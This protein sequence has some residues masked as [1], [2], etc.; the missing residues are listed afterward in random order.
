METKTEDIKQYI[1]DNDLFT[2]PS[3]TLAKRVLT[4]NPALFGEYNDKN[5]ELSRNAVRRIRYSKGTDNAPESKLFA[6][7]FHGYL[8]P[9]INDYTPFVIPDTVT[10]MGIMNDIHIPF[11]NKENLNA[12]RNI[13]GNT[14]ETNSIGCLCDMTPKYMPLN[15]WQA[16]FAMV[17]RDNDYYKFSNFLIE[18]G[19][20]L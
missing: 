7:R 5:I 19:K 4:N 18:N 1:I 6:E 16:G 13:Q 17:K 14:I 12:A 20:I 8:E 15:D 9:D 10:R 3:R 2:L 11:H